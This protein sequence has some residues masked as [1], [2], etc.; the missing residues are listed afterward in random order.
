M[1]VSEYQKFRKHLLKKDC[2]YAIGAAR[3]II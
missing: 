2:Q 1:A 3:R